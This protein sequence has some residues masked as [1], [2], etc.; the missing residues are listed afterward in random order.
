MT[1]LVPFLSSA[2]EMYVVCPK[3]QLQSGVGR[4][5]QEMSPS[6]A[7]PPRKAVCSGCIRIESHLWLCRE[8]STPGLG[9]LFTLG[10]WSCLLIYLCFNL[11]ATGDM[12]P[13]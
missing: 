2:G 10:I 11:C 8:T 6:G 4:S 7:P 12:L 3:E 13:T 5:I 9:A 1:F